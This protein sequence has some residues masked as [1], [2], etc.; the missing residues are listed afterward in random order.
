MFVII[1]VLLAENEEHGSGGGT[2]VTEQ[3]LSIMEVILQEANNE[4]LDH[5]KPTVIL[6]CD[7]TQLVV[8]LDRINSPFVRSH[9][10]VLQGLMRIIPF[11]SFG[12][13]D[14]MTTLVLHF[15][16]YLDFDK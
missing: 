13:K 6:V 14:K 10:T 9:S 8:L 2:A 3:L 4:P 5:G 1:Q 11:L 12:D 16:P 7:K 15:E